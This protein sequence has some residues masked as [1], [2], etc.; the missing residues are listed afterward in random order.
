MPTKLVTP[1][2]Y[3]RLPC[4]HHPL[5]HPPCTCSAVFEECSLHQGRVQGLLLGTHLAFG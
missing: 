2:D 4:L 1:R 5:R 3:Y